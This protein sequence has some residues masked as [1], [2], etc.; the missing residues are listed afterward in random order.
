MAVTQSEVACLVHSWLTQQGF[1]KTATTFV[2]EAKHML[3]TISVNGSIRNLGN[4]LSDYAILKE[5]ELQ[6]TKF[7][8]T[9]FNENENLFS[10]IWN[11]FN[12]LMNDYKFYR[13]NC[14]KQENINTT[15]N[16]NKRKR[17]RLNHYDN[18][19]NTNHND[20]LFELNTNRFNEILQNNALHEKM[21]Q[22]IQSQYN[23]ANTIQNDNSNG[24]TP[25]LIEKMLAM[26]ESQFDKLFVPL[27]V[28]YVNQNDAS[29]QHKSVQTNTAID[30]AN[31]HNNP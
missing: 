1:S 6:K 30:N 3:Q 23:N 13:N 12:Q 15:I 21:A 19:A 9:F 26:D 25:H 16:N 8:K 11:Q 22:L 5:K 31:D 18:Y 17:R 29:K 2:I 4:I 20:S 24:N 28:E 27:P 7:Q 14:D 10:D